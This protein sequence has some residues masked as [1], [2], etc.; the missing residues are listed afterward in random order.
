[1]SEGGAHAP[2]FDAEEVGVHLARAGEVA[3]RREMGLWLVGGALRDL[4][5]GRP[6]RDVDL[7][8]EAAAANTLDLATRFGALPG[9]TLEKTHARFGTATLRA[10]GGLRVDVAATRRE[11]YPSPASLPVVTGTTTIEDD[12]GRRDFTIHSMARRVGKRGLTGHVLDPFGGRRDLASKTLRL[13]HPKSLLDDPTRAYRAVMYAVRLG[14][15]WDGEFVKALKAARRAS[16]F[17]ALSGDRMRRGFEEIFL[18]GE[19]ERAAALIE[20]LELLGDVLPGWTGP[21]SPSK[22]KPADTIALASLD[23]PRRLDARPKAE[24]SWERLLAPLT[25][26]ERAAVASRLN[27]PK[28]LRRA[29]GAEIS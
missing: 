27:F 3:D 2:A 5:L 4:L 24:I 20:E 11:E 10:P 7:A 29:A 13:L 8:V 15:A 23:E 25:A 26:V 28:A 6:L 14:F 22:K 17:Q 18:E 12:L 19:W 9:W 21:Y 16:A 1:M